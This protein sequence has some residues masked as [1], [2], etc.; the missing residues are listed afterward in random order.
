MGDDHGSSL[1]LDLK[2]ISD[3][4]KSRKEPEH[5]PPT[6]EVEQFRGK[7]ITFLS[8]VLVAEGL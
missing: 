5:L 1:G 6:R 8:D 4:K 7:S 2:F 3:D